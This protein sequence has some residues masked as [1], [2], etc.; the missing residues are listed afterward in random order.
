MDEPL[1]VTA[2]SMRLGMSKDGVRKAIKRGT[3]AARSV[4]LG[5]GRKY[6]VDDRE[7]T[8]YLRDHRTERRVSE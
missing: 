5:R 3:L 8:R 6:V 2:A 1:D 4:R 7:V